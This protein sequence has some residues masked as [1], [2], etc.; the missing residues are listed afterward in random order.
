MVDCYSSNRKLTSPI[1][2]QLSL[3]RIWHRERPVELELLQRNE[4]LPLHLQ[5]KLSSWLI[6]EWASDHCNHHYLLLL[7]SQP[8]HKKTIWRS[9]VHLTIYL[10]PSEAV[11]SVQSPL[12]SPCYSKAMLTPSSKFY[13]INIDS[14]FDGWKKSNSKNISDHTYGSCIL[15]VRKLSCTTSL[16][17]IVSNGT[18]RLHKQM[19]YFQILNN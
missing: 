2:A 9:R 3:P 11:S 15:G 14:E 7:E 1:M 18:L 4:A 12:T 16:F 5:A 19:Q 8:T 10:L 13:L 17:L 6:Q